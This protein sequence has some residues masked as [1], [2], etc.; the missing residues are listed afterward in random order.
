M[1]RLAMPSNVFV[2]TRRNLDTA[3]TLQSPYNAEHT[4]SLSVHTTYQ[5]RR[6][7]AEG[8]GS[9]KV[10]LITGS[11]YIFFFDHSSFLIFTIQPWRTISYFAST[12]CSSGFGRRLATSALARGDRVI[13]TARV[14]KDINVPSSPN[15]RVLQ[16]DVTAGFEIINATLNEAAK[17]WGQIDVLV[18]NAGVGYLG[19]LE[20][21]R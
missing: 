19:L 13:A 15:L 1:R 8:D 3:S 21:G 12:G 6:L 4:Q 18:N 10:W 9:S 14:V 16:L 11:I 7:K 2:T 17:I 20:E 5:A